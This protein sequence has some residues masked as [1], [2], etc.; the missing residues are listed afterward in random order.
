[1]DPSHR[2][3]RLDR[4]T[5]PSKHRRRRAHT[6]VS[7]ILLVALLE[8]AAAFVEEP[9][10]GLLAIGDHELCFFHGALEDGPDQPMQ[11]KHVVC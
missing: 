2:E 3:Q 11:P 7:A 10:L 6:Y 9:D 4:A 8:N 1:M 5:E